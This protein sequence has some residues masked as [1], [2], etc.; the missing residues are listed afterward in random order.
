MVTECLQE[1]KERSGCLPSPMP[2]SPRTP[3]P[4]LPGFVGSSSYPSPDICTGNCLSP[5]EEN[6]PFCSCKNCLEEKDITNFLGRKVPPPMFGKKKPGLKVPNLNSEPSQSNE[7]RRSN[8]K[9]SG[10][11]HSQETFWQYRHRSVFKVI[12]LSDLSAQTMRNQL[13]WSELATYSGVQLEL[14]S[15]GPLG[16]PLEWTL[17]VKIQGQNSGAD[18]LVR[19][20]LL[21]MN[22]GVE[23]TSRICFD[24][25]IVTQSVWKSKALRN[26]YWQA[27]FGSRQM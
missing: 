20:K 8:G 24:G 17:I 12:G 26:R 11:M 16:N 23:L 10:P 22:F 9:R 6:A 7:T 14:A 15:H 13:E 21:S 2:T 5:L 3:S 18:T 25:W 1:D 4:T 27:Q 19:R